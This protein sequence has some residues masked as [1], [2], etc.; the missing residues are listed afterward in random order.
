MHGGNTIVILTESFMNRKALHN[1]VKFGS[2]EVLLFAFTYITLKYIVYYLFDIQVYPMISKLQMGY[3]YCL[4]LIAYLFYL[5]S[6]VFF[7]FVVMS[8]A[9]FVEMEKVEKV[10]TEVRHRKL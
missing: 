3:Y 1:K 4:G 7:K 10:N 8:R 5:I 6:S 9:E 2:L